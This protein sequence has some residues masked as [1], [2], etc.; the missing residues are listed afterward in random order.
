MSTLKHA[1]RPA[2]DGT[3]EVIVDFK[4]TP[5]GERG[6]DIVCGKPVVFRTNN[7]ALCIRCARSYAK[8]NCFSDDEL[9]RFEELERSR[10][11]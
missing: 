7:L 6:D 2:G 9:R 8:H 5:D 10:Q 3:C 11:T 4:G 1:R